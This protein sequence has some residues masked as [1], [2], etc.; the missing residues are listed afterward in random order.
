MVWII[1]SLVHQGAQHHSLPLSPKPRRM[2]KEE[3]WCSEVTLWIHQQLISGSSSFCTIKMSKISF[4]PFLC[5]KLLSVDPTIFRCTK[6][7]IL[8]FLLSEKKAIPG[9]G[10]DSQHPPLFHFSVYCWGIWSVKKILFGLLLVFP[11]SLV[12]LI[13]HYRKH[14]G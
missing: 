3:P 11:G 12:N 6:S 14:P 1:R 5:S 4:G 13:H 2:I 9:A 8:V 10:G 7:M